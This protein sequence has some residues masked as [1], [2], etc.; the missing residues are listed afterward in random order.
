MYVHA[1]LCVYMY[2][3][4]C[5]QTVTHI[6]RMCGHI[7]YSYSEYLVCHVGC[8]SLATHTLTTDYILCVGTVVAGNVVAVIIARMCT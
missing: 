1:S 7:E 4:S 2:P 8:H 6:A 3:Q 5:W